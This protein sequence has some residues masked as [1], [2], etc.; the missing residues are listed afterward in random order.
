MTM[1]QEIQEQIEK[2]MDKPKPRRMA[3]RDT[4]TWRRLFELMQAAHTE[5]VYQAALLGHSQMACVACNGALLT[6]D[7]ERQARS[8]AYADASDNWNRLRSNLETLEKRWD[9][10]A[11][12]VDENDEII[13]DPLEEKSWR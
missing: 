3:M 5:L 9:Y 11:P 13:G 12:T 10:R 1:N 2:Q 8:R 4:A 7:V 6:T